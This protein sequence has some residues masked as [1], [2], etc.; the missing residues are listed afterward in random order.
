MWVSDS[1]NKSSHLSKTPQK[2][3]VTA[4]N[5]NSHPPPAEGGKDVFVSEKSVINL[6][7]F[8]LQHRKSMQRVLKRLSCQWASPAFASV[9][10]C[11]RQHIEG[12]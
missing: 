5:K 2:S 12:K 3:T 9:V 1:Q 8:P 4:E 10:L 11:D 7:S 6:V